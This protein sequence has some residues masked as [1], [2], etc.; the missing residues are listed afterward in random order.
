MNT[1]SASARLLALAALSF[2]LS[3]TSDSPA[4]STD[5]TDPSGTYRTNG[6]ARF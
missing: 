2:A 1:L 6:G 3:C 5:L 4:P